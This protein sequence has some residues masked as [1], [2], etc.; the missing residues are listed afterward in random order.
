MSSSLFLSDFNFK[1]SQF[2]EIFCSASLIFSNNF[3]L[4]SLRIVLS[5]PTLTTTACS[6]C[7]QSLMSTTGS[8]CRGCERVFLHFRGGSFFSVT[9]RFFG[10]I[11]QENIEGSSFLLILTPLEKCMPQILVVGASF[12]KVALRISRMYAFFTPGS[13]SKVSKLISGEFLQLLVHP[14][15]QNSKRLKS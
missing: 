10:L 11:V 4:A 9:R 6:G 8:F 3:R 1:I 12:F 15:V 2:F 13:L 14:G 5:L 7:S